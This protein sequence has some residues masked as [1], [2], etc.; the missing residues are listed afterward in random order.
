M[1]STLVRGC[2]RW[3]GPQG[4]EKLVSFSIPN[5]KLSTQDPDDVKLDIIGLTFDR[6]LARKKAR[7][8][9]PTRKQQGPHDG[10]SF[11]HPPSLDNGPLAWTTTRGSYG[12]EAP[13]PPV[14]DERRTNDGNQL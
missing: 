10:A 6:A 8:A 11:S 4:V 1:L 14:T 3:L 12:K 2:R 7:E 5:E 9:F 13:V